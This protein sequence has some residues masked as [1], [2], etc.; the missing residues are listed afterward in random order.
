LGGFS[1]SYQRIARAGRLQQW[2]QHQEHAMYA[3]ANAFS[4]L[5]RRAF[6][7]ATGYWPADLLEAFSLQMSSHGFSVSASMMLGD[8]RYA[9]EQL[10]LAHTLSDDRLR[11]L[12]VA[13]FQHFERQQPGMA[14]VQ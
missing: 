11:E 1:G 6:L 10:A 13:L 2:S 9:I 7:D 14:R 5:P 8:R 3:S 12:A 4:P